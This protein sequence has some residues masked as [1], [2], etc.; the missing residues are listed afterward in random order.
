MALGRWRE[1]LTAMVGW[2]RAAI[3]VFLGTLAT[4][5]LP[6]L[7]LL[8]L[9]VPAMTGLLWLISAA[10]NRRAAFALGWWFGLGHFASGF[11]WISVALLIDAARFAWMIPFAVFGLAAFFALF[12]GCVTW[13]AVGVAPRRGARV[14]A[15]AAAWAFQEWIRSWLLTGFPWNLMA[16]VWVPVESVL[17]SA[18]LVGP[19]GLGLLT[20]GA[21]AAPSL[22]A[23]L[24]GSLRR[25]M[26]VGIGLPTALFLL[27]AVGGGLRLLWADDARVAGVRLRLVQPAIAQQL[28]W[29]DNMRERHLAAHLELS[30]T[31][32]SPAPT[33]IIWSETA[34]PFFLATDTPIRELVGR[35]VPEGGLLITGAPRGGRDSDGTAHVWNSLLAIDSKARVVGSFDKFHLVP[36]GEYVPLRGI[37]GLNKITE[38]R[39]DFS[40]GPGLRTLRLPGLPPVSPLICYEIIFPGAVTA[41]TDRPEW[42]LNITNDGWFGHSA[43]PYQHFAAARLRAVEEGLPVVR[44]ANTGISGVVDGY[45]RV[46]ARL[47]L[48]EMGYLDADLPTALPPPPFAGMGDIVTALLILVAAGS[49][50]VGHRQNQLRDSPIRNGV[51]PK[52]IGEYSL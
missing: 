13:L 7:H 39:L 42:I 5:A 2:R 10:P 29:Q 32:A 47:G 50:W 38:G 23:Q 45:G 6:P 26:W 9:L 35:I 1:R 31:P 18:A 37:I 21:A 20:V 3:A 25:R 19:Y 51:D 46:T 11:Y 17:Q 34:V 14:L 22:V 48:G 8:P 36:F 30:S 24:P 27:L 28:K 15:F 44:V 16:T 49:G 41:P 12:T 43:G 52:I 33:H 4:A 40:S